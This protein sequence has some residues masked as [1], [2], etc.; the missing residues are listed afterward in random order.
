MADRSR[1]NQAFVQEV[2]G[3]SRKVNVPEIPECPMGNR[4]G[5]IFKLLL[6]FDPE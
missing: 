4:K 6:D 5:F 2:C 1:A 3:N